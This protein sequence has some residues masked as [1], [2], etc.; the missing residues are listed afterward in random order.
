MSKAVHEGGPTKHERDLGF[1]SFDGRSL[2]IEQ[3]NPTNV[4]VPDEDGVMRLA[5]LWSIDPTTL[6]EQFKEP[7]MGLLGE[8][9]WAENR[10]CR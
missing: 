4:A 2:E 6:N 5:C 3:A 1:M 7:L 9:A 10:P 8:V